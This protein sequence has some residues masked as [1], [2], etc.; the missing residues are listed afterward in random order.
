VGKDCPQSTGRWPLEPVLIRD[1]KGTV[2]LAPFESGP[3][4]RERRA[5]LSA[6]FTSGKR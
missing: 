3:A 2:V 4:D 1:P 6:Y 5:V